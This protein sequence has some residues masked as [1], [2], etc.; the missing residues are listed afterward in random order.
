MQED[1]RLQPAKPPA[2]L[3]EVRKGLQKRNKVAFMSVKKKADVKEVFMDDLE[4]ED[5]EKEQPLIKVVIR[6]QRLTKS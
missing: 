1:C 5:S 4:A 2:E 6:G 3:E